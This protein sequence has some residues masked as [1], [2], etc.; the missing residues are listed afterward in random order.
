MTAVPSRRP[1][2]ATR[3]LLWLYAVLVVSAGA[4]S[5]VQLAL[6]ATRAPVAYSLSAVAAAVYA[7]G[8]VLL[9]RAGSGGPVRPAAVCAA[10]ELAGVLTVGTLSLMRPA[11]F[12]DPTVW[13]AY[14]S[15][16]LWIPLLLP[17]ATLVRLR[18]WT[19]WEGR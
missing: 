13:S 6:H 5:T 1:V 12:P 8:F 16:Y 11:S 14:G 2:D 10:V 7:T 3:V 17:V 4:R 19:A 9:R 15:G 18:S